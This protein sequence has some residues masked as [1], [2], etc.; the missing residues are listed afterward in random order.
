MK[1][2]TIPQLLKEQAEAFPEVAAQ[3]SR[4]GS[5]EFVAR[6]YR[7]LFREVTAFAAGLHSLGVRAGSHVGLIS[8]NRKEWL[9]ADLSVLSLGAAD[10]PRGNDSMADE[11]AYILGFAECE[12]VLVENEEQLRKVLSVR[13]KIE[14]L[15]TLVVLDPEFEKDELPSGLELFRYPE[16]RQRGEELLAQEPKLVER[17]IA[18]GEAD[19]TATIIF[20][21]GT[22]GVPKGV[23][24]S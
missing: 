5:G 3:L 14:S 2:K 11:I 7:D 17:K 23:M 19:D 10:V 15:K 20:T 4:E 6:S 12:T 1:A 16:V 9:V 21:S 18:S 24:L 8:E 22:T 13:E